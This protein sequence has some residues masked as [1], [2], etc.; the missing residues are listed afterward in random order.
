MSIFHMIAKIFTVQLIEA[1]D[2][3]NVFVYKSSVQP[4]EFLVKHGQV[5]Q[6][7]YGE[8]IG[9]RYLITASLSLH[10]TEKCKEFQKAIYTTSTFL[11]T[12]EMLSMQYIETTYMENSIVI[13]DSA[14][15]I[16]R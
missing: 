1:V 12:S 16:E 14:Q 6:T 4:I 5:M 8:R 7:G 10:S 13:K 3:T 15:L 9:N 11:L 2:E